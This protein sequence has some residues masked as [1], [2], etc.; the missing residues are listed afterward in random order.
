MPIASQL[1]NSASALPTPLPLSLC[2]TPPPCPAAIGIRLL[3]PLSALLPPT[4]D[5]VQPVLTSQA[6]QLLW[7][8][9]EQEKERETHRS[10]GEGQF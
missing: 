5:A 10:L 2:R 1:K 7:R 6:E 8:Q 4:P 9:G 3:S